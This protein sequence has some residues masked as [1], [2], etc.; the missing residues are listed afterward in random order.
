LLLWAASRYGVDATGITLS[1]NQYR[2]VEDR[3]RKD[4][5][6]ARCRVRLLDYRDLPETERF[7]KIASIGMFEHVGRK[8]LP[9]YF[10]KISRLLEP[11]GLVLNHGITLGALGRDELASDIG[12]FIDDYVFPDGELIHVSRVI[13]EMARQE[14]ECA[15]VENL[16]THYA[17]TL[18]KWVERLESRREAALAL[19]GEKTFR[20]WRIYMAG[21]AHAFERGWLCIFQVLAAKSRLDGT[22]TLPLT[23]DDIYAAT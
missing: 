11:G 18:W 20:V 6:Q 3:I 16:R 21:S 10:G 14:L 23:R 22:V 17:K 1:E 19:V 12:R 8:N 4:G 9:L 5:L 2:Y 15:D 7:G 13:E